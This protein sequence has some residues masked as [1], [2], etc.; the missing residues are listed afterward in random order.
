LHKRHAKSQKRNA[1]SQKRNAKMQKRNAKFQKRNAKIQ[2][3]NAKMQKMQ[4]RNAKMQKRNAK[5]HC[6]VLHVT[7]YQMCYV[8]YSTHQV[9]NK[10]SAEKGCKNL[11]HT[12]CGGRIQN[13]GLVRGEEE[14]PERGRK[15]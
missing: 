12:K 4:R 8:M 15:K 13:E 7:Q 9:E 6:T 3:R 10:I 11:V 1:K 14:S 5:I 2:K